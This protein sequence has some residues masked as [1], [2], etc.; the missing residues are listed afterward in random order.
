MAALHQGDAGA[1]EPTSTTPLSICDPEPFVE[2]ARK[3][4][5]IV[6]TA[7]PLPMP[8]ALDPAFVVTAPYHAKEPMHISVLFLVMA[9]REAVQHISCIGWPPDALTPSTVDL[10]PAA[11]AVVTKLACKTFPL[12]CHLL[13]ETLGL[14]PADD[15]DVNANWVIGAVEEPDIVP[16]A[17]GFWSPP[18]ATSDKRPRLLRETILLVSAMIQLIPDPRLHVGPIWSNSV[19]ALPVST[20][21]LTALAVTLAHPASTLPGKVH[22]LSAF[23]PWAKWYMSLPDTHAP[24][25]RFVLNALARVLVV[26][27][28]HPDHPW[29]PRDAI[30][31]GAAL[32]RS[33]TWIHALV[34]VPAD[35]TSA[36]AALDEERDVL[37]PMLAVAQCAAA[38]GTLTF[39]PTSPPPPPILTSLL[40]AITLLASVPHVTA[41]IAHDDHT[42]LRVLR[43]LSLTS[44]LDSPPHAALDRAMATLTTTSIPSIAVNDRA[45]LTDMAHIPEGRPTTRAH[46]AWFAVLLAHWDDPTTGLDAVEGET[47][48]GIAEFAA[49]VEAAEWDGDGW[50][51]AI[52]RALLVPL[53]GARTQVGVA[54]WVRSVVKMMAG[55]TRRGV[56]VAVAKTLR[57]AARARPASVGVMVREVV[58]VMRSRGTGQAGVD[59]GKWQMVLDVLS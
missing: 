9:L 38:L 1:M 10:G 21:Y 43:A 40:D 42:A 27:P 30:A 17:S 35:S 56:V 49:A 59:P 22:P 15:T 20:A 29:T 45:V 12:I 11:R 19:C 24:N 58:Q 37:A 5:A 44:A 2:T 8:Q 4:R 55:A 3:L 41:S 48:N 31:L 28:R 7:A 54:R 34:Q 25:A 52:A 16:G 36:A 14:P 57:E 39:T 13:C 50:K 6:K 46:A 53:A 23:V 32:T 33:A 47:W 18:Y 26:L 51:M